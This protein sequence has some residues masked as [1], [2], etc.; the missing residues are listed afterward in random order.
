M[1]CPPTTRTG[2]TS[3]TPIGR[4]RT[5]CRSSGRSRTTRTSVTA[6]RS[7]GAAVPCPIVRW[8]DDELI[9]L[10]RQFKS[11][12]LG[13]GYPW[14]EDHNDP[15]SSGAGMI[16]M[17]RRG[18]MRISSAVAYLEPARGRPNLTIMPSTTVDR[19][20]FDGTRAVGVDVIRDG[21]RESIEGAASSC[22]PAPWARR[23]SSSAQA[24]ARLGTS[25]SSASRWSSTARASARTSSNTPS[26][27]WPAS[28]ARASSSGSSRTYSS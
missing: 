1:G 5:S 3:G 4:G 7:T 15:W 25:R 2:P 13:L 27:S 26:R 16:P 12:A 10:A 20:R 14:V 19:V 21:V 24:S 17:N 23:R 9:P 18:D 28:L 22:P 11:A 8:T 6:R